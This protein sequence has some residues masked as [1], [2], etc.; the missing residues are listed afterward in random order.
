MNNTEYIKHV[1]QSWT[2]TWQFE[3]VKNFKI[4]KPHWKKYFWKEFYLT[5]SDWVSPIAWPLWVIDYKKINWDNFY[6]TKSWNELNVYKDNTLVYTG[7]SWKS[8]KMLK[9]S[10][11]YSYISEW[12]IIEWATEEPT[13]KD[14]NDVFEFWYIKL[15]LSWTSE[16]GDYITFTSNQNNLQAIS[17]RIHYKEWNYVYIRWTNLYATIPNIGTSYILHNRIWNIIVIWEKNKVVSLVE[18]ADWFNAITLYET[19]SDDEVVDI[20]KFNSSFFVL[21]TKFLYYSTSLLNSNANIYPLDFFDN[22]FGWET[23]VA[24]W[25]MLIIFW[26]ENQIIAPVNWTQGSLWYIK[27]DLNYNRRLFSKYS[28]LSYQWAL[29]VLQDDKQFVK[30]DIINTSNT[31]YDVIT[32]PVMTTVQW[33]LEWIEWEAFLSFNEKQINIINPTLNW[34]VSYNYNTLHEMWT[35]GEYDYYVRNLWDIPY[36]ESV[37]EYTTNPSEQLISFQL[38]ADTIE[39]FKTCLYLKLILITEEER[40]P[41]YVLEVDE[42]IA[43]KKISYS[44]KLKDFPINNDL[45]SNEN[46]LWW[47]QIW[48]VQLSIEESVELWRIITPIITINRTANLFV[49][50]LKNSN[51]V[52]TDGGS[53][54]WYRTVHPE[55]NW[56]NYNILTFNNTQWVQ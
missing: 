24:F 40:I 53:L 17:T 25:K 14:T 21:T 47:E 49:F 7:V 3:E 19:Q 44:I 56:A 26:E 27:L 34:T 41:D 39:R 35:I 43:W 45:T 37:F 6:L 12:T 50:R 10:W 16:I 29:Y 28:V 23:L 48:D 52:I 55:V 5:I 30:V 18:D 33:M 22:T 42:Y 15:R 32:T 8:D 31:E 51:N 36:W 38:W 9:M 54:I 46:E 2:L 20:E 1:L 13:T 4:I 11:A